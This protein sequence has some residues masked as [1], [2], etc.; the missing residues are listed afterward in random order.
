GGSDAGTTAKA[1]DLLRNSNPDDVFVHLD[2]VDGAGHSVGTNGAA[3]GAALRTADGRLGE[4]LAAIRQRASYA[5]EQW[6]V[7]V[8]ADH[9]HTPTGGHG[10]ATPAERK[11][12][13]IAA[14]PGIPA[15]SVRDDVKIVDIAPTILEANGVAVEES[16][17]LDGRALD[18]RIIDPFDSLRPKLRAQVDETRPGAGTLGWTDETPDGWT[19]DNSRMPAGGVTEWRGWSFATDEF[20]SNAELKQGRETSVRNRD[21]FAVADSD[22]WDDKAHAGGQFDSTLISPAYPLSGAR[23][24]TLSYATNYVIDGPQTAEVLVSFDGGAPQLLKAYKFDTNRV[25]KVAVD[26]PA[27]ARTAQFSFRYTGQNS[28]FW[29]VDQVQLLQASAPAAPTGLRVTAG[30]KTV[31]ASWAAPADGFDLAGY[32]VTATPVDPRAGSP[33]VVE[34]TATDVAVTGLVNGVAYRVTVVARG[35]TAESSAAEAGPVTPIAQS[36][37]GKGQDDQGQND[38]DQ[39]QNGNSQGGKG[40]P[41]R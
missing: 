19:I 24:A 2:D 6:L 33:V 41:R 27:G 17:D 25:E 13:V 5:D 8:T 30:D 29:T 7:V 38:D 40:K 23:T 1:V 14:G 18:D 31:A 32:T 35:Y 3:Y 39:G 34:T 12:F 26:V 11:T 21:V 20:W 16:A 9:G 37:P 36:K 4:M 15:G 22:E 28:A 10:G